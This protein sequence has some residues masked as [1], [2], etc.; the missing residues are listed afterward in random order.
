MQECDDGDGESPNGE[1]IPN[2]TKPMVDKRG[3]NKETEHDSYMLPLIQDILRAQFKWRIFVAF[4]VPRGLLA[5]NKVW[6]GDGGGGVGCVKLDIQPP[7][8]SSFWETK[9]YPNQLSGTPPP[10]L[11]HTYPP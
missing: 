7:E 5:F 6:I 4:D 2:A 11:T 8:Q 3:L 9:L 1:Y 10:P